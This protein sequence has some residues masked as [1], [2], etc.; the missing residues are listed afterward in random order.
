MLGFLE[1][2]DI[3]WLVLKLEISYYRVIILIS[4]RILIFRSRIFLKDYIFAWWNIWVWVLLLLPCKL[5]AKAT[6]WH[7]GSYPTSQ[8]PL[9]QKWLNW[10]RLTFPRVTPLPHPLVHHECTSVLKGSGPLNQRVDCWDPPTNQPLDF[11]SPR[12]R[13]RQIWD[14]IPLLNCRF[15]FNASEESHRWISGYT[16]KPFFMW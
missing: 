13:H 9:L 15:I 5:M 8:I 16:Y 2:D 12:Q 10:P 11:K 4:W 1:D 14:L 3:F 7:S 6:M